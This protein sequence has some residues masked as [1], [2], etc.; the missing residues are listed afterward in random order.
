MLRKKFE[1]RL[2]L[3]LA[4]AMTLGWLILE[5]RSEQDLKPNN[6]NQT[7]NAL[8]SSNSA[9]ERSDHQTAPADWSNLNTRFA[10]AQ[11]MRI[12]NPVPTK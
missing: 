4:A 5:A 7:V 9:F 2:Y 1:W 3:A 11:N 6:A 12:D 8:H 10:Q